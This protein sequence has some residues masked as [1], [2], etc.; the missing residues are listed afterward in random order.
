MM[1]QSNLKEKLMKK[2]PV[3]VVLL[4]SVLMT[5]CSSNPLAPNTSNDAPWMQDKAKAWDTLGKDTMKKMQKLEEEGKKEEVLK[6]QKSIDTKKMHEYLQSSVEK[7]SQT[8][9]TKS[10]KMKREIYNLFDLYSVVIAFEF[11]D[12]VTGGGSKEDRLNWYR[13][14]VSLSENIVKAAEKHLGKEEPTLLAFRDSIKK[15]KAATRAMEG[16]AEEVKPEEKSSEPTDQKDSEKA[17]D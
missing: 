12:L 10:K 6:L 14:N 16:Q 5:A 11:S 4:I 2:P 13:S 9:T 7:L 15:M 17:S 3:L 8:E 1:A